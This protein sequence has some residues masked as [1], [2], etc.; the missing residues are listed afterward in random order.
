MVRAASDPR[1]G[2]RSKLQ[3]AGVARHPDIACPKGTGSSPR[4]WRRPKDERKLKSE[5][6]SKEEDREAQALRRSPDDPD[7][8]LAVPLEGGDRRAELAKYVEQLL[9]VPHPK[10]VAGPGR[11][12]QVDG[13]FPQAEG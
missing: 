12:L 1:S 3:R 11:Q 5:R 4:S 8:D 10:E 13:L 7:R 6:R 2:N 9:G